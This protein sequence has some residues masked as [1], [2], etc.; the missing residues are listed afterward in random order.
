MNIFA[1][2]LNPKKASVYHTD[3]H[4]VKMILESAQMLCAA[5][6][7]G[8]QQMLKPPVLASYHEGRWHLGLSVAVLVAAPLLLVLLNLPAIVVLWGAGFC[9]AGGFWLLNRRG[10]QQ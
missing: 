4:V 5:H 9:C 7:I 10:G 1:L 6:W 3:K 2:D 8:W